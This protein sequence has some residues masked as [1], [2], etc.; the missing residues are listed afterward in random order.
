MERLCDALWRGCT[1]IMHCG[2]ATLTLRLC[3][4]KWR[5]DINTTA[6]VGFTKEKGH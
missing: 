3:G 1:C 6:V 2:E 4:A 5:M